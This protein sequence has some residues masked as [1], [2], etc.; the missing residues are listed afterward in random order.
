MD[1]QKVNRGYRINQK[2]DGTLMSVEIIC[3]GK[4]IGEIRYRDGE[5]KNCP[6]CGTNHRITIQHNHFHIDQV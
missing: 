6:E 5:N 2:S 3:C 1:Q 4:H